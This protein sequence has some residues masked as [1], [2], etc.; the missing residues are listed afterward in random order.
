MSDNTQNLQIIV[1]LFRALSQFPYVESDPALHY[2]DNVIP[3]PCD[4]EIVLHDGSTAHPIDGLPDDRQ[5]ED[6]GS[7]LSEDNRGRWWWFRLEVIS[8]ADSTVMK[9][10]AAHFAGFDDLLAPGLKLAFAAPSLE[11]LVYQ[12]LRY[13]RVTPDKLKLALQQSDLF[14]APSAHW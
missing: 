12:L 11:K 3:L 10:S 5:E 2:S 13:F 8:M 4:V 14:E 1:D 9:R 6:R 7:A